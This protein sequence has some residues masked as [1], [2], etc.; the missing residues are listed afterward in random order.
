MYA[1][2]LRVRETKFARTNLDKS[3]EP[4]GTGPMRNRKRREP[5]GGRMEEE[6][7]G[8]MRRT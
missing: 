1:G 6:A 3:L 7:E 5:E 4:N 2:P 8:S